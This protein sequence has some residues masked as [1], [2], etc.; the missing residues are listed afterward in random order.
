MLLLLQSTN[1]LGAGV[2]ARI[3]NS[4]PSRKGRYRCPIAKTADTR[5][6]PPFAQRPRPS[7]VQLRP[8]GDGL[9]DLADLWDALHQA[10][11]QAHLHGHGARRAAAASAL[12]L[13]PHHRPIDLHHTNVSPGELISHQ[14]CQTHGMARGVSHRGP[15]T[16]GQPCGK[17]EKRPKAQSRALGGTRTS[18]AST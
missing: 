16:D 1:T 7:H 11:L 12:Q 10:P 13:Q 17:D 2:S 8:V 15:L 9:H 4:S 18:P 14:Q 5:T 3:D 6:H